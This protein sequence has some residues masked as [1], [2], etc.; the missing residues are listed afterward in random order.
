MISGVLQLD[1]PSSTNFN[2]AVISQ[3]LGETVESTFTSAQLVP[4]DS[5]NDINV[6]IPIM[7]TIF[8]SIEQDF[9]ISILAQYTSGS[10]I[11]V[12]SNSYLIATRI[13]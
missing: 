12:T 10:S 7:N 1:V 5:P 9:T 2:S 3:T 4:N 11:N 13:A 8:N 6:N